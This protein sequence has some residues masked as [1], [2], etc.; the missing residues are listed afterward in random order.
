MKPAGGAPRPGRAEGP[1]NAL[2]EAL[3]PLGQ[4]LRASAERRVHRRFV[5]AH[6]VL[7]ALRQG[8]RILCSPLHGRAL[9]SS[10]CC[11]R[12][13]ATA[14][15]PDPLPLSENVVPSRQLRA[16]CCCRSVLLKMGLMLTSTGTPN[17]E[18]RN[19][20]PSGTHPLSPYR[21]F[22]LIPGPVAVG[23]VVADPHP[24]A[25]RLEPV[26][27]AFRIRRVA[28]AIER[29]APA[30]HIDII[31]RAGDRKLR[32]NRPIAATFSASGC[33]RVG[34]PAWTA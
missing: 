32:G 30:P 6:C 27:P 25:D 17:V 2:P 7:A 21:S 26:L 24:V 9:G 11:R 14:R 3:D 1:C 15:P 22:S 20:A 13:S 16:D 28:D 8:Q 23:D 12:P 5:S 29:A 34:A 33:A 31:I 18:A 4:R 10:R 19:S